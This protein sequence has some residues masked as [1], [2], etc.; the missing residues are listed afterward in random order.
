MEMPQKVTETDFMVVLGIQT[1][2]TK[3][4]VF[5]LE[6][7]DSSNQSVMFKQASTILGNLSVR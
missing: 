1:F 3:T 5:E 6:I 2:S 7:S 4:L